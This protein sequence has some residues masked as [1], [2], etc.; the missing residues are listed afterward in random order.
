MNVETKFLWPQIG[1]N[2]KRP[3][4]AVIIGDGQD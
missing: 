1:S 2:L 3:G 4:L